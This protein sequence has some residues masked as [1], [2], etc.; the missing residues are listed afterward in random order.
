M[1]LAEIKDS[2]LGLL[3]GLAGNDPVARGLITVWFLATCSYL[4]RSV[5]SK[6]ISFFKTNFTVSTFIAAGEDVKSKE[7]FT[8]YE[9]WLIRENWFAVRNRSTSVSELDTNT[10]LGQ[11]NHTMLIRGRFIKVNK[12]RTKDPKGN[13]DSTITLTTPGRD[14]KVFDYIAD[15]CMVKDSRRYF[16][17]ISG[18]S[19][20]WSKT[21]V[22]KDGPKLF[23]ADD[24]RNELYKCLDDFVA[25]REWYLKNGKPYRLNIILYGPPG[26]GK[27]EL[28]RH[29]SDYLKSDLYSMSP[30]DMGNASLR[31][32]A[33][34]LNGQRLAVIGVED[35]ESIALSRTY[36]S[37]LRQIS[38]L[39][40]NGKESEIEDLKKKDQDM[41][42]LENIRYTGFDISDFLNALQGLRVMENLVIVMTTNHIDMID[43]AVTRGS[44]CN[45]KL[46]VGPLG[47]EQVKGKFE[48]QYEQPFPNYIHDI[49]PIKACDLDELS[50]KNAFNAD[51]FL[52]GL[53]ANYGVAATEKQIALE[54]T[55]KL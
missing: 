42:T 35:F 5:P 39:R 50:S 49:K 16:W 17:E 41:V 12:D 14:A 22:I 40:D 55:E 31:N 51:G 53:I 18:W 4:V 38:T 28:T 9:E 26:T 25:N 3:N 30:F 15:E 34:S 44:R 33:K 20:G 21:A 46:Y 48:H 8:A 37:K 45:L 36:K 27:T 10:G 6:I 19:G 32:A 1:L 29:I 11:G 54:T 23:L 52:T 43:E 47:L 2:V 7:F 13:V 24:V